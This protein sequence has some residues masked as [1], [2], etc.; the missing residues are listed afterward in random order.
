MELRFSFFMTGHSTAREYMCQ[1]LR[2]HTT[3]FISDHL[4]HFAAISRAAIKKTLFNF[5]MTRGTDCERKFVNA[6]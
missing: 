1:D 5:L 6:A 2:L 4:F 3:T